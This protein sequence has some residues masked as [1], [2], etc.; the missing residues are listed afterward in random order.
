ML[1]PCVG[2]QLPFECLGPQRLSAARSS[3]SGTVTIPIAASRCRTA[4]PGCRR[5]PRAAGVDNV[6][7]VAVLLISGGA[8][9]RLGEL[10][11]NPCRIVEIKQNRPDAVGA[12]RADAV[13]EHQPPGVGFDGRTAVPEL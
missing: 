1:T 7:Y 3:G 10:T 5:G 11:E 13:S 2:M 8:E 9:K 4:A 6:G 12:H